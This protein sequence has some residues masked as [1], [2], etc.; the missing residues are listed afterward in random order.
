MKTSAPEELLDRYLAGNCTE[1]EKSI[2]EGWF[3]KQLQDSDYSILPNQLEI[4]SEEIWSAIQVWQRKK[5]IVVAPRKIKLWQILSAAAASI[6]FIVLLN[7][8]YFRPDHKHDR[9]TLNIVAPATKENNL[10]ELPDGSVV[11]LGKG[12]KLIFLKSFEGEAKRE[13]Y[14][15]GKA[16]F[17]IKHDSSKPFIVHS[18]TIKTTVLGTAFDINAHAGSEE[19]TV[20]VIRGK[21]NISTQKANLGDLLP[22]KQIIYHVKTEQS[23][24]ANVNAQKEMQWTSQDM[25]LNDV[26]FEAICIQLENRYGVKIHIDG[27]ALKAKKSTISLTRNEDLGGFL[28][29]ICD[30][31]DAKFVKEDNQI[32]ITAIN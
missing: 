15:T 25:L 32:T 14:L 5:Q 30:F 19:I 31:N 24:F 13:V 18:G 21:V 20:R 9:T 1:E 27:D 26:T 7:V 3:N 10:I 8:V 4:K 29:T 16:F 22:N 12:S 28:Q 11:I 17:D 6:V 2:V 23:S